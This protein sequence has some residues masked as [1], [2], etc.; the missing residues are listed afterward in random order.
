MRVEELRRV[1]RFAV[2]RRRVGVLRPPRLAVA[3]LAVFLLAVVR[4]AVPRLAVVFRLLV[5][6]FA[7]V[8]RPLPL[9]VARRRV[10]LRPLLPDDEPLIGEG[11]GGVGLEGIGVG[12]TEPG[13][14]CAD[15]SVP[16]SS[17][18][19]PPQISVECSGDAYRIPECI[20][21]GASGEKT[22]EDLA[23]QETAPCGESRVAIGHGHKARRLDLA[24]GRAHPHGG[25]RS[26]ARR[27]AVEVEPRVKS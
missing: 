22:N 23:C 15:Q 17:C 6:R 20:A 12:Q 13:S 2:D 4:F 10:V 14:F 25:I 5:V 11:G 18:M 26:K 9:V 7:V 24:E 27:V 8:F 1:V 3:R 19:V 21:S 16:S